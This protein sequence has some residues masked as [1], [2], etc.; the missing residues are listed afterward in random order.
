M[1]LSAGAE[2]GEIL[3]SSSVVNQ[4]APDSI[5]ATVVDQENGVFS[6]MPSLTYNNRKAS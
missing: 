3:V 5:S 4:L 6:I 1:L 2:C